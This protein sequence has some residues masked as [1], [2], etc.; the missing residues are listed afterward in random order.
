MASNSLNEMQVEDTRFSFSRETP[1]P[2]DRREDKRFLKILRVGTLIIDGKRELCLLRNISAGG[3]MAHVY[4]PIAIGTEVAVELK[5]HMVIRGSVAWTRDSNVGITF[6]Q[7]ID[8][9]E[10]LSHASL[11][12]N[13]WLPRMPR[14]EVDWLATARQGISIVGVT[15]RDISQGGVK[16]EADRPLEVSKEVVLTIEKYRPLKGS[17]RWYEDR[18]GGIQFNEVIPFQEL[19]GWL[20]AS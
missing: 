19:M 2:P 7:P 8:V 9:E 1:A 17:V 13:G 16:F 5:S 12:Q 3:M 15:V 10:M 6:E 20:R 11:A 4:S 14:I 18:F